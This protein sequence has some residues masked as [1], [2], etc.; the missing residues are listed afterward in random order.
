MN[1]YAEQHLEHPDIAYI[2]AT[3]LNPMYR[4]CHRRYIDYGN[5]DYDVEGFDPDEEEDEPKYVGGSYSDEIAVSKEDAERFNALLKTSPAQVMAAGYKIG[6]MFPIAD[7]EYKNG[8]EMSVFL[9]IGKDYKVL[10]VSLLID[11]EGEEESVDEGVAS[12]IEFESYMR[13]KHD[14]AYTIDLFVSEQ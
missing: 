4:H 11:D 1:A 14:T 9:Q 5:G 12:D 10:A 13:D 7:K 3:G 8:Y 6:T 2:E